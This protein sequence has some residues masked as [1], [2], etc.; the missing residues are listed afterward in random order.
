[1]KKQPIFLFALLFV[2]MAAA[3]PGDAHLARYRDAV[4]G[5]KTVERASKLQIDI[6]V[7]CREWHI[8]WGAPHG[9]DKITPRWQHCAASGFSASIRPARILRKCSRAP[10]GDAI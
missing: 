6:P 8:W 2:L 5:D 1:M 7:Y 9:Q 4:P 10:P 3:A